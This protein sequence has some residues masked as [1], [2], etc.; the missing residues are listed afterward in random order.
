MGL[1]GQNQVRHMYVGQAPAATITSLATLKSTGVANDLVL[2]GADGD[3]VAAGK[4]FKMYQKDALGNII[5]SDTIKTDNVLDVRSVAYTAA[6]P[7]VVTISALTVDA[8]TL[9]TVNILISGHGSLSPED[10]YLKQGYYQAVAGN[11]QEDIVDGLITSLNRNFKREVGATATT[12]R[13]FVFSKTGTGASAALVVTGQAD[14]TNFDGNK[15]IKVYDDFTV[16]IAATTYPTVT[17]TTPFTSGVGT[18]YQ[19]VEMEWFLLGER[20]D[21]NRESGYPHNIVGP[22]LVSTAGGSYDIIEISYF[23]EGRD[24]AKKSKKTLTIAL[25][26]AAIP[27]ANVNGVIADLNTILGASSVD[28]IKAS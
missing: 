18:G 14:A 9:Y 26:T 8:G 11:D 10:E 21:C 4:A 13:S 22:A 15:K 3:A 1:A 28:T 5:S 12:N 23:D 27:N 16:D 2:L 7:K 17:V 20:G 19:V 6:T 24:E 25:P